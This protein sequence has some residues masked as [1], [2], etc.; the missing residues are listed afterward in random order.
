[1]KVNIDARRERWKYLKEDEIYIA[2]DLTN[3]RG[4]YKKNV[5]KFERLKSIQTNILQALWNN[6]YL[7]LV[8]FLD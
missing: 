8:I 6:L 1:M 4:V 5:V 2:V 7:V 3:M